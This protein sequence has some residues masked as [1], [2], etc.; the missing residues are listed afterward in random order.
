MDNLT[1]VDYSTLEGKRVLVTGGAGF[2]G[3]HLVRKL[4]RAGADVKVLDNFD[5][6]YPGKQAN[7]GRF[8]DFVNVDLISGSILDADVVNDLCQWSS[9]I[10]HEAGQ[11]GIR[12]CNMYPQKAHR[13]NVEGTLNVLMACKDDTDKRIVNASSS[14]VYGKI[15]S[16]PIREDDPKMPDSPYAA[17]KLAAEHYCRAFNQTYSM[18]VVSLRYFSVYGP[19]Q[20]PDLVITTFSEQLYRGEIPTIF[21]DG[22]H[23][24]DFTFVSDIVDGTIRAG[25]VEDIGGMVFNLGKGDRTTVKELL[26]KLNHLMKKDVVARHDEEF[27]GEFPHTQ[28]E[29]SMA[30]KHLGYNPVV[31]LDEGLEKYL[32]W[33]YRS[34][35]EE[36]PF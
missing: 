7:L 33:F 21:G 26:D 23:S 9:I 22:S 28:A 10:F 35:G 16:L 17:T 18:D 34:R 30:R 8:K 29:I 25:L 20:R 5:D 36:P 2:I 4:A 1:E 19:S 27:P 14:S 13:V 12:Y 11:A 32:E 6:F 3:S 15:S 24:R 31:P